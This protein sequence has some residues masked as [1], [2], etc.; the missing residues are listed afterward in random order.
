M[1]ARG[2]TVSEDRSKSE[3]KRVIY[4]Y[5]GAEYHYGESDSKAWSSSRRTAGSYGS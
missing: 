2:T 3:L 5:G 4:S 1:Y